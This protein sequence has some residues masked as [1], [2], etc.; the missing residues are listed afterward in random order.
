MIITLT[1]LTVGFYSQVLQNRFLPAGFFFFFL[2]REFIYLTPF[3]LIF[4]LLPL[5]YCPNLLP[6]P[7]AYILVFQWKNLILHNFSFSSKVASATASFNHTRPRGAS[8]SIKLPYEV[9]D[10]LHLRC[11]LNGSHQ[12]KY[13][14]KMNSTTNF[15]RYPKASYLSGK[16]LHHRRLYCKT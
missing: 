16:E 10:A 6:I 9:T 8:T 5:Q 12:L 15:S 2:F 4:S 7:S 3:E 11:N 1:N 14:L 13:L